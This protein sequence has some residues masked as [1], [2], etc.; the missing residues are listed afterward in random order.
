MQVNREARLAMSDSETVPE[1]A[2]KAWKASQHVLIGQPKSKGIDLKFLAKGC[3]KNVDCHVVAT[4]MDGKTHP[5]L[6]VGNIYLYPLFLLIT[7]R[8][9]T[10]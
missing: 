3:P 7:F 10:R 1:A 4:V 8:Y 6:E 9:Y 2:R 5:T